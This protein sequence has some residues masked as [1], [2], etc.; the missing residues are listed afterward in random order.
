MPKKAPEE[1]ERRL[2]YCEEVMLIGGPQYRQEQLIAQRFGVSPRQAR[3]YQ[4]KV[5]ERWRARRESIPE[6]VR[7]ERR[8]RSRER[9]ELILATAMNRTEVVKNADGEVVLDDREHLPDGSRNP[10]FRKPFT[11]P[12]PYLAAAIRADKA[13]RELDG[14]NEP[15]KV[16]HEHTGLVERLPDL[17]SVPATARRHL[18]AAVE[19]MAP[20]GDLRKLAAD[21][22]V[23][24]KRA[25]RLN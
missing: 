24:E 2:A 19:A 17:A 25:S 6:D 9:L 12:A 1:M 23:V 7:Q 8:Q 18:E 21:L 10:N 22:F 13:L 3:N 15:F 16:Q 11:R 14:L 4:V 5:R 20:D